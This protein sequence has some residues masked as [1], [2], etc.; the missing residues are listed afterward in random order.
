VKIVQSQRPSRTR[1]HHRTAAPSP[2][3]RPRRRS[4]PPDSTPWPCSPR[5]SALPA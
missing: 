1:R 5:R 2:R 3:G 4:R